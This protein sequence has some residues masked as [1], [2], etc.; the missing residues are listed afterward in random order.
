LFVVL[1]AIWKVTE[2]TAFDK[3]WKPGNLDPTLYSFGEKPTIVK[4]INRWPNDALNK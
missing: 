2:T 4:R 1:K 3:V